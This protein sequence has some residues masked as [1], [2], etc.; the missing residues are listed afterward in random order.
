MT[1]HPRARPSRVLS[2]TV[3]SKWNLFLVR[4][5]DLEDSKLKSNRTRLP[6]PIASARSF[7]YLFIN[8]RQLEEEDEKDRILALGHSN[9]EPFE[10]DLS[11]LS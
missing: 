10:L 9:S 3:Q 11:Q 4:R 6:V 7:T 2:P 8:T 5:A 1:E